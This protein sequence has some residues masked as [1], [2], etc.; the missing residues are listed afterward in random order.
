[1][2]MQKIFFKKNNYKA[3]QEDNYKWEMLKLNEISTF[4]NY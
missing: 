1:M 3:L 2:L 4:F